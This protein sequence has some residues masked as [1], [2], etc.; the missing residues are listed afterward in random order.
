[1]NCPY[2]I[3]N[4]IYHDEFMSYCLNQN[5]PKPDNPDHYQFCQNCGKSLSLSLS[6]IQQKIV[7]YRASQVI[8]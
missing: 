7:V 8:G 4:F 3:V 5:C 2:G 6:D 1:M